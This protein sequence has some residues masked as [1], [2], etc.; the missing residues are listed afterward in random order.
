MSKPERD[1]ALALH[2]GAGAVAGRDYAVTEEH[3]RELAEDCKS[4]LADGRSALDVVEHAVAE[5][6]A[7]GLY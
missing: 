6:E 4:W 7:S 1:Y 2:G 3:L 5:L